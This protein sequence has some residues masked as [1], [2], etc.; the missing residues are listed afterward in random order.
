MY[1]DFSGPTGLSRDY[2]ILQQLKKKQFKISPKQVNDFLLGQNTYSS[3]KKYP[4]KIIRRPMITKECF[5]TVASDLGDFGKFK[6]FNRGKKWLFLAVDVTSGYVFLTSLKQKSTECMK[7]AFDEL[8]SVVKSYGHIV[9]NC[10]SD[11]G[12]EYLSLKNYFKSH[13]IAHYFVHNST[14][15]FYAENNMKNACRKLY[16]LMYYHNN[17]NWTSYVKIVMNSINTTLRKG[18]QYTPLEIISSKKVE[19]DV[20]RSNAL[21]LN[22]KYEIIEKKMG[23]RPYIL[24]LGDLVRVLRSD[25]K[26][27]EKSTYIPKFS[28]KIYTIEK[29]Y[30]TIPNVY[31]INNG[32]KKRYYYEE[33][34]RVK[35][36]SDN[37]TSPSY[38]VLDTRQVAG[39]T[40]RS[41]NKSNMDNEY[42][43]QGI[44]D[45]SLKKWISEKEYLMLMKNN[46]VVTG[47]KSAA[48]AAAR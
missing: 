16:L 17:F 9:K 11:Q 8:L 40:L 34:S 4:K 39:R 33:L 29:I 35:P 47:L 43:L 42:L 2:R 6:N 36:T 15:S 18:E 14:K 32:N 30:D 22:K 25:I 5:E 24:K 12:M 48:P 3:F 38:V 45:R 19:H 21:K 27:F 44:K 31:K 46:L 26:T 10:H 41:G 37:A 1:V 23:K 13:N 7:S 20:M 28:D